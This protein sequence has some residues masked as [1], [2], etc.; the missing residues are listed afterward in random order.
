MRHQAALKEAELTHSLFLVSRCRS[1]I[2]R[3]TSRGASGSPH[4]D[5]KLTELFGLEIVR[6]SRIARRPIGVAQNRKGDVT[7]CTG[8]GLLPQS[9]VARVKWNHSY[10]K[11]I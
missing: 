9:S 7:E 10:R 1:E 2:I 8:V 6:N 4:A 11:T 3:E 5:P